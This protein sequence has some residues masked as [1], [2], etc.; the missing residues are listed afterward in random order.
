MFNGEIGLI[1]GNRTWSKLLTI[2]RKPK[3]SIQQ[4]IIEGFPYIETNDLSM[5]LLIRLAE[6]I[7]PLVLLKISQ[8]ALI[9]EI[10]QLNHISKFLQVDLS[11]VLLLDT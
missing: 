6:M 10:S 5:F 4:C 7:N 8:L 3:H 2:P 11:F 1:E 9:I